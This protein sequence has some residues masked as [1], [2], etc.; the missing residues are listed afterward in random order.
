MEFEWDED[1]NELNIAKHAIDFQR[2]TQIFEGF[3]VEYPSSQQHHG[4]ARIVAIGELDSME[5]TVIYTWRGEVR[6]LISASSTLD[7]MMLSRR[8][9]GKK[10]A[11]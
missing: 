2:A 5:V 11:P 1:K 7:K 3:V 4:E 8:Q 10:F 9:S 6:R